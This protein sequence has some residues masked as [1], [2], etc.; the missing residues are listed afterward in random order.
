MG[1]EIVLSYAEQDENGE[2][3]KENLHTKKIKVGSP[4][5][6]LGLEHVAGKIMAQLAR[7]AILVTDVK[8]YEFVKKELQFKETP[9][10]IKIKN[11]LFKFDGGAVLEEGCVVEPEGDQSMLE[12]L[13]A[14]PRLN[15]IHKSTAVTGKVLREELYLPEKFLH[16]ENIRRGF[17]V[18]MGKKYPIVGERKAGTGYFY[19][20]KDDM[21]NTVSLHAACF[22]V[23]PN[24][25]ELVGVEK[26]NEISLDHG[27]DMV[28]D[29]PVLRGH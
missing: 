17:K 27:N 14:N 6:E 23:V 1:Y 21:G 11:K 29:M 10:G 8:I 19:L 15:T 3:D 12:L 25:I 5:E 24:K 28:D 13:S 26:S 20:I 7:R 4:Y 22:T 18:T 16:D 9:T 2:Y